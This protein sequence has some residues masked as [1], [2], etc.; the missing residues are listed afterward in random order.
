[1]ETV[2]NLTVAPEFD[3]ARIDK[4]L[5]RALPE[6]SRTRLQRMMRHGFV[7]G[8]DGAAVADTSLRVNA[9]DAFRVVV[10]P[11][12]PPN[13]MKA[14]DIALSVLFED[15][16]VIVVDKPAG[17]VVHKGAGVDSGTLVNALLFH[18]KGVLSPVGAALERPGI[19]HRLDK[20]TSGA[21]MAC[22]SESAHRRMYK[23]FESHA[24]AREYAA[25]V[26]GIP[27]PPSGTI[28]RNIAR[29]PKDHTRFAAVPE[30]G[31]NAV[32][33]YETAEVFSG[34][35][36]KPISL[37]RLRLETGRTHQIRV[38]MADIGH[39]VVGDAVYGDMQRMLSQVESREAKAALSNVKRQML[40]SR[41]I[42]FAHPSTGA[43]VRCEADLP[44]D[45]RGLIDF[46][47][48]A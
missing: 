48:G 9:G 46:L 20:G 6:L 2:H 14:E 41:S 21:M 28:D 1:M 34:A 29:H 24:V 7:A 30:G 3:G 5:A 39:P 8:P 11:L 16:D 33:H 26:W 44:E 27:N 35:K 31:K 12:K 4:W 32:T 15:E 17:M 18:T 36:F 23:Q 38:H 22:K 37:L 47:R 13:P 25:L 10:E 42:E 40:H 43:V 19:V 45:M